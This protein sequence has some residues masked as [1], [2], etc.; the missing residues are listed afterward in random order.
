MGFGSAPTVNIYYDGRMSKE[1]EFYVK[2]A[3]YFGG[4]QRYYATGTKLDKEDVEFLKKYKSG[5]TGAIRDEYRRNLWNM[6]YGQTYIHSVTGKTEISI[7]RRGQEVA[8]EM[9]TKFSFEGF[10]EG[11]SAAPAEIKKATGI[12]TD[13]MLEYAARLR[14]T[15]NVGDAII[16][17][18]AVVSLRRF[19]KRDEILYEDITIDFLN[20][21]EKWMLRE[22]KAPQ[23][24]KGKDGEVIKRPGTPASIT[25][26]GMYLR[27]VR[28][29][30]NISKASDKHYPF[31]E[32]GYT[33]PSGRNI[34][35]ALSK[36]D[37]GKIMAYEPESKSERQARD[38]WLFS[39]LSNGINFYDMLD[40]KW[41]DFNSR[42]KSI[43]FVRAKTK[44]TKKS[45][46]SHIQIDLFPVSM[47]IIQKWGDKSNVYIFP[48]FRDKMT[49][50]RK[51]AVKELVV[52]S[53]NKYM[54]RIAEKLGI[55]ADITTYTARHSF[56]TILMQSEAPLAFISQK[57]D[58]SSISTT[59][60]YLGSFE[61]DQAKKYLANLLPEEK[62]KP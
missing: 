12:L 50:E 15:D 33:I 56:A 17:E 7:L 36:E 52:K 11:I 5:L 9:G 28:S 62:T 57:L 31:G 30:F 48:F 16:Y 32:D 25:T 2:Y 41:N 40:L 47:S 54:R 3:V 39:Y 53:T 20:K 51:K 18:C 43:Q 21:Y 8:A 37:I 35:K 14:K 29:M 38:L 42:E 13:D 4:K 22:G 45:K 19:A 27:Q 1:D 60:N 10:A 24:K 6:I 34:K 49:V 58:H 44:G 46:Q 61:S 23:P 55:T 26:I 59:Q